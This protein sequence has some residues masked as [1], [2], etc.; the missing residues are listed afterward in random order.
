ME[1][2]SK[3]N[4]GNKSM[5][6]AQNRLLD[7][8]VE[9]DCICKKFDIS[10]WLDGGS[11]LGAVRHGG[12]IPWDDDV[13]IAVMI[14]DYPK[15]V[16]ILE[17]ELP[18]QF[19]VQN[20]HNEKL[21]HFTHTR[22]V[23]TKSLSDYGDR[24]PFRKEFK[25]QGVFLDV[26]FIEK[27]NVAI[28]KI[29]EPV[30]LRSFRLRNLGD[31]MYKRILGHISWPVLSMIVFIHR[32]IYKIIP[33]DRYIFGFGIPFPR[34][35]KKDEIFPPKPIKFVDADVMGPNKP[36]EYLTRYFGDYMKIPPEEKRIT[37]AERI[38]IY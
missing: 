37:H 24:Q 1:D 22:V 2:F 14:E 13:D 21:F 26:F 6:K 5:R 25:Y 3:Y 16:S 8:L 30:Y 12:F 23:D 27:G 38:E 7:M 19:V 29:I 33:T 9:V 20:I 18:E 11:A 15:L 31:K 17:H 4:G 34:E 36:D 35:F 32:M 10:Y 28:K